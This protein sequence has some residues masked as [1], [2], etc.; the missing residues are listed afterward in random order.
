VLLLLLLLLR[1]RVCEFFSL[2]LIQRPFPSCLG[3][4][5]WWVSGAGDAIARPGIASR[6]KEP[7]F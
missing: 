6:V 2:V 7:Y 1:A 4:A 3:A 5:L